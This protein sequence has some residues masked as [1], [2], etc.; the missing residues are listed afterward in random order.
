MNAAAWASVGMSALAVL[1]VVWRSAYRD[2]KIDV[3]L[4][5]LLKVLTDHEE[6]IRRNEAA[7]ARR[8]D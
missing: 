4:E 6:R 8:G 2:G 3:I 1:G 5:Q 7:R